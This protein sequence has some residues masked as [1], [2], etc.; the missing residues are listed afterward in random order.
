[1]RAILLFVFV[2]I[3]LALPVGAMP[4]STPPASDWTTASGV[5]FVENVGQFDPGA[6]FQVLGS[7]R[8]LWLADDAL[9]ITLLEQPA[10]AGSGSSL[11]APAPQP[12]RNAVHLK[13]SYQG[14][15]PHP[16]L[17]AFGP[18]STRVSYFIGND[19]TSWRADVPVWAGVRYVDLY[20][21]IDL[22]VSSE[23]GQVVQR[24]VVRGGGNLSQRLAQVK[25][26]VEGADALHLEQDQ[27]QVETALGEYALALPRLSGNAADAVTMT[28]QVK[29]QAVLWPFSKTSN[30][31]S[32]VLTVSEPSGGLLYATFLGGSHSETGVDIAVDTEGQAYITGDTMSTDFPATQ[33]PGYDTDVNGEREA[34]VLKLD[35]TGT[36]LLYATFLGG[37][38]YDYGSGIAVDAEGQA[39]IAGRTESIDFP[40]G[41]GYDTTHNSPG[42]MF[43]CFVAKL[44]AT[45]TQLLYST[46]VGGSGEEM[47]RGIA[48]D[49]EGQA[50]VVG[51]TTSFDF[52]ATQGPGYDTS[53][54]GFGDAFVVK[55]NAAG[56]DLVYATF[57]GGSSTDEANAIAVDSLGQAYVTGMTMSTDF[58][59]AQ[60]PGYDTTLSDDGTDAF[61][62]KLDAAGTNLVYATFLGGNKADNGYAIAVDALG[63]A[64]VAG[65]TGSADFPVGPGYDIVHNHGVD[66]FLVKLGADGMNLVYG[67]FLGGSGHDY[68]R[69]I[70][71][72]AAGQVYLVGYT[73]STDLTLGPGYDTTFH[74]VTDA[75]VAKFD[76]SGKNLLYGTFLGGESNDFGMA[77]AIGAD[78]HAYVTGTTSS[79]DFP[80]ALGPGYDTSHSLPGVDADAY[81]VALSTIPNLPVRCYIPSILR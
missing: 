42:A 8:T 76:A 38:G 15:N 34:Y 29:A 33:G 13:L 51:I 67:T 10:D 39:Y 49:A 26:Q 80:A 37:S 75:L 17:E 40:V 73:T 2:S 28:P 7:D 54:D 23:G 12:I 4:P 71:L 21:G 47:S 41:P 59:A 36:Q 44:D 81:V 48:L 43:D 46:F 27:L 61:A 45:G 16:R 32:N 74:N 57:L 79:G 53:N 56:T 72:D 60:G 52:P 19:Q 3:L 65:E 18:L 68:G 58:P 14:A 50:Y 9:W 55:L 1:M 78:D 24:L 63:Q 6:R 5:L 25:L 64:Y 11:L 20:P 69:D 31:S 70:A 62:I 77:I 30:L 66:I 35:A 22:E